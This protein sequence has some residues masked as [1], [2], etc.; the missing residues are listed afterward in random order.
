MAYFPKGFITKGWYMPVDENCLCIFEHTTALIITE[1]SCQISFQLKKNELAGI[2][3]DMDSSFVYLYK[4]F[5]IKIV[6]FPLAPMGVLASGC[7][8]ARPSAWPP[9]DTSGNFRHT[10]LQSNLQNFEKKL[11][12]IK[13]APQ[14]A[15]GW[16]S[17]FYFF[18]R[19]FIYIS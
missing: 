8:H 11:K 14:G 17:E 1:I 9:I 10:C 4:Q 12:K 2:V 7:A 18:T 5:T 3:P 6:K 19:I 15:R 13:I 16:G